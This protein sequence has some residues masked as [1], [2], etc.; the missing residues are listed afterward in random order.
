MLAGREALV[1]SDA[2]FDWL[3]GSFISS[4]THFV[5]SGV[6]QSFSVQ[7]CQEKKK[8]QVLFQL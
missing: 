6:S 8:K 5:L 4:S 3:Y 2:G 1:H 7:N